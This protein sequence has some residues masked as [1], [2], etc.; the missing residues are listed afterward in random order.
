MEKEFAK[1]LSR[2]GKEEGVI[3]NEHSYRC[4]ME[5]CSGWRMSVRWSNGRLTFPCTRGCKVI[6]KHTLKI[7]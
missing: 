7:I 3:L 4:R 2:D 6:G 1:I 5:G